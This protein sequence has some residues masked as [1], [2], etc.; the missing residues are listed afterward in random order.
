MKRA[1]IEALESGD[2]V[3]YTREDGTTRR[4]FVSER[5]GGGIWV[6]WA[7]GS[8]GWVKFEDNDRLERGEE[9]A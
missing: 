2:P 7:D 3:R 6:D 4:G 1:E 5:E 8:R 9:R